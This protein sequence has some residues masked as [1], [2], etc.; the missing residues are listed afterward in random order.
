M[1]KVINKKKGGAKSPALCKGFGHQPASILIV[2]P[3]K[4][5]TKKEKQMMEEFLKRLKFEIGWDFYAT[6]GVRY[7][8]HKLN[9]EDVIK[10]KKAL[11]QDFIKTNPHLTL[12]MGKTSWKLMFGK[13][14]EH[15]R[16]NLF[17]TRFYNKTL[18]QF[19]VGSDFSNPKKLQKSLNKIL[20]YIRENYG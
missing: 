20:I 12:L 13:I 2:F 16:L 15:L 1:D 18:R 5:Q 8:K 3:R 10:F 14:Y 17:Y 4:P 11:K 6:Y 7:K 9:K 19:F